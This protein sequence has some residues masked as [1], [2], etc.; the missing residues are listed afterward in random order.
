MSVGPR[1]FSAKMVLSPVMKA[2]GR[3][4]SIR[5]KM[6]TSALSLKAILA[7]FLTLRMVLVE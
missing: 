1:R 3:A 7:F 5:L 6:G 2:S 4:A